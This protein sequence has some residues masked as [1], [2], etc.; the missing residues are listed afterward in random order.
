MHSMRSASASPR[1]NGHMRF[2]VLARLPLRRQGGASSSSSPVLLLEGQARLVR[3]QPRPRSAMSRRWLASAARHRRSEDAPAHLLQPFDVDRAGSPPRSPTTYPTCTTTSIQSSCEE[4]NGHVD[5]R[6][7]PWAQPHATSPAFGPWEH[8]RDE[9]GGP[10]WTTAGLRGNVRGDAPGFSEAVGELPSWQ[11]AVCL[12]AASNISCALSR[13][14][15]AVSVFPMASN[16]GWSDGFSG[17]VQSGFF[18]GFTLSSFTGGY[19]ATRFRPEALLGATVAGTSLF[20]A[21]TPLAAQAAPE[22]GEWLLAARVLT[23][24]AEGLIYPSIQGLISARVPN[25]NRGQAL[26]LCYSGA[27]V[28]NVL[29]LITSPPLIQ[30]F[31]WASNFH[32]YSCFGLLWLASWQ[33][34]IWSEQQLLV[35]SPPE[36]QAKPTSPQVVQPNAAISWKD[37]ISNKPFR[38]V[39]A[40]HATYQLGN[41]IALSWLP[42]YFC[43][44]FGTDMCG[45]AAMS[46]AP[47]FFSVVTT[48]GAGIL[49]DKLASTGKLSLLETRKA[50][51][52]VASG[53]PAL[54][55]LSLM[56]HSGPGGDETALQAMVTLTAM[57]SMA[58]FKT[59]GYG[60]NFMELS[61]RNAS[62]LCGISTSLAS[63]FGTGGVLTTGFILQNL[64]SWP[65]VFGGMATLNLLSLGLYLRDA[66][67]EAQL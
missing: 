57:I 39:M 47:W 7:S 1:P 19:L 35:G 60:P 46:S 8:P 52:I 22:T 53:G 33:R 6:A 23:G 28:G 55:F 61:P 56:A 18:L 12:I 9:T 48:N 41:L 24:C 34:L 11:V 66:D 54:C 58:Q 13:G 37:M 36:A 2:P 63:I 20:T 43:Q 31:G 5:G 67:V 16:F 32:V 59:G 3:K 15:M 27:E 17:L 38:A 26:G 65:A 45:S 42:T 25:E 14:A 62:V 40:S 64:H 49:A 50:M 30:S 44:Q 29:A 4:L 10:V 21:L 51:Q